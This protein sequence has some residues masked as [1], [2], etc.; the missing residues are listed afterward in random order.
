MNFVF[1][2]TTNLFVGLIF[3]L[4]IWLIFQK[5]RSSK[6]VGCAMVK[7]FIIASHP[8]VAKKK[9]VISF[10][11]PFSLLSFRFLVLA[12]VAKH[13]SI[14]S[15]SLRD[16]WYPIGDATVVMWKVC[17]GLRLIKLVFVIRP[18]KRTSVAQGLF[19][20]VQA[21]GHAPHASGGIPLKRGASGA[22][23]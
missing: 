8:A 20:G 1:S 14:K 21:Q 5:V 4:L 7:T 16:N 23:K 22:R 10:S 17:T 12:L 9:S 2:A 3:L 18:T 15:E 19:R 11:P 6:F 13:V